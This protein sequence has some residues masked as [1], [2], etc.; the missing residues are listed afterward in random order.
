MENASDDLSKMTDHQQVSNRSILRIQQLSDDLLK[1]LNSMEL[2]KTK[3]GGVK[4]VLFV[5]VDHRRTSTL[6]TWYNFRLCA[7]FGLDPNGLTVDPLEM[8]RNH[9]QGV[10]ALF[11]SAHKWDKHTAANYQKYL[12]ALN[13]RTNDRRE[14]ALEQLLIAMAV[15]PYQGV[16]PSLLEEA[17]YQPDGESQMCPRAKACWFQPEGPEDGYFS[18]EAFDEFKPTGEILARASPWQPF[19]IDPDGLADEKP[20]QKLFGEL[21]LPFTRGKF[22]STKTGQ[23]RPEFKKADDANRSDSDI[24]GF[25]IP[26][27]D[28]LCPQTG[29]RGGMTGWLVVFFNESPQGVRS[30]Y[31][32]GNNDER[33]KLLE[34]SWERFA[35][36][37]RAYV[38]RVREANMRDLLEDYAEPTG[39]HELPRDFFLRHLHQ[40]IGYRSKLTINSKEPKL[41]QAAKRLEVP[42]NNER[43]SIDEEVFLLPHTCSTY[44]GDPGKGTAFPPGTR[45]LCAMFLDE[46]ELVRAK[47]KEGQQS[48][49]SKTFHDTSK[50]LNVLEDQLQ[51]YTKEVK[52]V[53][54]AVERETQ[55][56]QASESLPDQA[57]SSIERIAGQVQRLGDPDLDYML[58]LQ[59]LMSHLRVQTEGRLSETPEWAW[60]LLESGTRWDIGLIIRAYVWRPFGWLWYDRELKRLPESTLDDDTMT[61][62]RI[63]LFDEDGEESEPRT[64]NRIVREG[65]SKVFRKLFFQWGISKADYEASFPPPEINPDVEWPHP[66]LWKMDKNEKAHHLDWLPPVRLLPP[67]IFAMRAAFEHAYLRNYLHVLDATSPAAVKDQKPRVI[68]ISES[69]GSNPG[70]ARIHHCIHIAFPALGIEKGLPPLAEGARELATL[71]YDNWSRHMHHYRHVCRPWHHWKAERVSGSLEPGTLQDPWHYEITLE[72]CE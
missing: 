62:S 3:L 72:A 11:E 54:E 38:R 55:A 49:Q 50:D 52:G 12:A 71:P 70:G 1:D 23:N 43:P 58:R 29:W 14:S 35:D 63:F 61:W 56:L 69:R 17:F 18:V 25:A 60:R 46:L 20:V 4:E 22:L 2:F 39:I 31:E 30:F 10:E 67:F 51:R 27:Y 59:F 8:L 40:V 7:T 9:Q 5:G 13:D 36:L 66:V 64:M 57:R 65:I 68:R 37:V 6:E 19:K 42:G 16:L 28:V 53:R 44:C 33:L 24:H 34:H 48:G 15:V 32:N 26:A 45:R 41:Q 47:R 21:L